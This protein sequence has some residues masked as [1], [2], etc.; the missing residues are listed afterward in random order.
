MLDMV[1]SARSGHYRVLPSVDAPTLSAQKYAH[2][3]PSLLARWSSPAIPAGAFHYPH[4]T[5][6]STKYATRMTPDRLRPLVCRGCSRSYRTAHPKP[7]PLAKFASTLTSAQSQVFSSFFFPNRQWDA[8]PNSRRAHIKPLVT[9]AALQALQT[10]GSAGLSSFKRADRLTLSQTLKVYSQ[11]SKSRL[12]TLVTLTAMAGVAL[13]P[14][15]TTVPV[16]ISTAAGTALCAASANTFNQIQEVPFDAQMA[17]T[18]NRPLVRKAITPVHA[19]AFAATAGIAGPAILWTMVTPITA[20]LGAANIGLYAGAYTWLKRRSVSNT[21]V[22]AV[23]GGLPPLMGWAAC[24]GQLLPSAAYPPAFFLPPVLSTM[25]MELSL[26]DNALSPLALFMLLYSWQFPHFNSFAHLVRA[27]YAQAGYRM[28]SVLDPQKNALVALRHA[29]T[30]LP[31]CS[32][33]FPLSGLTTWTFGIVS[34]VPNMICIRAA[35]RFW[36]SGTEK[37]ARKLWHHE[38]WYLPVILALMMFFK[39]GMD[40]GRWLGLTSAEDEP[41]TASAV[42]KG[43]AESV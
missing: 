25:P 27:S 16:L 18:R 24:G 39:Q 9:E 34:I 7:R 4:V 43:S 32:I 21:W 37:D 3:I 29:A 5:D 6:D 23:V 42:D 26:V 31:V 19:A 35:W 20:V 15:P 38:L 12:T 41:T 22:G 8:K 1:V 40:W 13:S 17:R 2:V 30:L 36:R 14:L 28:L 33:L 11:L 10:P